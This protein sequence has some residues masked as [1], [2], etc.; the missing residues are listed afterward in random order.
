MLVVNLLCQ[1]LPVLQLFMMVRSL[2]RSTLLPSSFLFL[3]LVFPLFRLLFLLFFGISTVAPSLPPS[4]L[5]IFS[6]PSVVPSVLSVS[7]APPSSSY[8]FPVVPSTP[9]PPSAPLPSF[10]SA[11]SL[12]PPFSASSSFFPSSDSNLPP[13]FQ[14]SSSSSSGAPLAPPSSSAL[15]PASSS[16]LRDFASF[17]AS[18][19]GLSAEYQALGCWFVASGGTDFSS[20]ISYHFLHLSADFRVD[21]SSGSSHFLATLASS[22]SIPP[23]SS[24]S[25]PSTSARPPVVFPPLPPALALAP[26]TPSFAPFL[27]SPALTVPALIRPVVS[28]P[29]LVP[30]FS[31]LRFPLASTPASAPGLGAFPGVSAAP[32]VPVAQAAPVAPAPP[33]APFAFGLS[34][35]FPDDVP[36]DTLPCDQEPAVPDFVRS[37]F[38]RML[39]FIVD[40]FPQAV[41]SP[42]VPPPPRALFEDFFGSSSLPSSPVFLNW[43]EL[44]HTA[45]PDADTHMSSFMLPVAPILPSFSLVISCMQCM[46]SLLLVMRLRLIPHFCL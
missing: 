3:T 14:F 31:A 29:S 4:T 9:F 32:A 21:F 8:S 42:A 12:A 34:E 43:F 39:A 46:L 44:V 25:A 11:S 30:A 37:E 7:S 10:S 22:T 28:A 36:P 5:P 23:P 33:S 20:N 6:L 41:G 26:S 40:L 16:S 45:L 27:R 1:V 17:Q 19:W 15:P 35:D 18:V 38:R 24:S 13:S 2:L